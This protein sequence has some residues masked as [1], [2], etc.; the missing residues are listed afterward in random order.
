MNYYQIL[1]ITGIILL[2][3]SFFIIIPIAASFF[4]GENLDNFLQSFIIIFFAG[5]LAYFPNK[6]QKSQ[7]KIREG[8]LL[9]L[10][11]GLS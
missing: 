6:N 4:Y 5:L 10:Y 8:F 2:I 1:K 9:L 3:F 11:F 7:I